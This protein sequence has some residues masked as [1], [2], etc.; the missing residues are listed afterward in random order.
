MIF[1]GKRQLGKEDILSDALR[2]IGAGGI[3]TLLTVSLYQFLLIFLSHN[4]A[5]IVSWLTGLIFLITVY[6]SKVFVG[7]L[8]SKKRIVAITFVYLLVFCAGLWCLNYLVLSGI[9][10]RLAIF[11]VLIFS[12]VLN[13]ILMRLLLRGI[14]F[15]SA[16]P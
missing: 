1:N 15:N 2:F 16:D 5:Y 8:K 7:G 11:I 14:L 3:N 9:H 13:F 10:E 4:T 12:T 6:P